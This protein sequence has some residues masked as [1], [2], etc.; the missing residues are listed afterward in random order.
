MRCKMMPGRSRTSG[1]A[2]I[3]G[4]VGETRETAEKAI[5]EFL[6]SLEEG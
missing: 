5:K 4:K 1:V 6:D 2:A 3:K